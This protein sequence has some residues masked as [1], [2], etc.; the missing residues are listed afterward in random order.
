[1]WTEVL[2]YIPVFKNVF[3]TFVDSVILFLNEALRLRQMEIDLTFT[4]MICPLIW[5]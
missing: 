4:G 1:M 2:W 3:K 5:V